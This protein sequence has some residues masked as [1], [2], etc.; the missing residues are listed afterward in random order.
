MKQSHELLPSMYYFQK[1]KMAQ[2][3]YTAYIFCMD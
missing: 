2:R 1:A 3:P